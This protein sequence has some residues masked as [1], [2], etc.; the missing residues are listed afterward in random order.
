MIS[1]LEELDKVLP[2]FKPDLLVIGGLQMM[3]NFPFDDG[4]IIFAEK[5]DV[6]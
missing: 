5:N 1:A 4:K 2:E 3:D 6:F